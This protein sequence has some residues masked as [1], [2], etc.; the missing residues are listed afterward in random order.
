MSKRIFFE[1]KLVRHVTTGLPMLP[2]PANSRDSTHRSAYAKL[3]EG[4]I[5]KIAGNVPERSDAA[6][7]A[8]LGYN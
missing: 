7:V 2:G 1:N 4:P 8:I 3:L 6:S 5:S